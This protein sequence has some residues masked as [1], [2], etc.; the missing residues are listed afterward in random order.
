MLHDDQ[1]CVEENYLAAGNTSNLR[2]QAEY[3][4]D[5]DVIIAAG[6]NK[7]RTGMALL[8]LHS[9]WDRANKPRKPTTEAIHALAA[10]MPEVLKRDNGT[11]QQLTKSRRHEMARAQAQAWYMGEM[12]AAVGKLLSLASVREQLSL[13]VSKASIED[14]AEKVPAIIAYWLDQTCHQCHGLKFLRV[15]GTPALSTKTCRACGGSG[16][17]PVPHGQDGRRIANYMDDCV[18]NARSSL[19][20][21]LRG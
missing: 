16:A 20:R 14:A 3:R 7:S 15:A 18:S 8:R 2:V 9:E 1:R 21:R 17:A 4:N 5:A 13:F 19:Q 6:W 11:V 10:T 12:G